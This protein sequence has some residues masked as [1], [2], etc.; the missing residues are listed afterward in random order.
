[1]RE[2]RRRELADVYYVLLRSHLA[3]DGPKASDAQDGKASENVRS[4][5]AAAEHRLLLCGGAQVMK[6]YAALQASPTEPAVLQSLL[7]A[8]RTATQP[9]AFT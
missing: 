1:M 5:Q 7:L 6:E 4:D 2:S 8:M 9:V 3:P